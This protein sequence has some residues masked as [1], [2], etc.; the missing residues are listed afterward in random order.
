MEGRWALS[1]V[2]SLGRFDGFATA[3]NN[4]MEMLICKM[5]EDVSCLFNPIQGF[6]KIFKRGKEALWQ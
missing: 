1:V 3:K 4:P 6:S 5:P 2:G